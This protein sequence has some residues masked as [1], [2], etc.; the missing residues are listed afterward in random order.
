MTKRPRIK[1][2]TDEFA[3]TQVAYSG[4]LS[5]GFVSLRIDGTYGWS[6]NAVHFRY[7]T[8]GAGDTR[9]FATGRRA[10]VRAWRRWCKHAGLTSV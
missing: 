5:I 7:I 1:W 2:K 6:L 9:D 8:K 3:N 4:K 10:L